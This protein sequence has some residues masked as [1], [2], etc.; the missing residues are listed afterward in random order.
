MA[1]YFQILFWLFI[2]TKIVYVL[3]FSGAALMKMVEVYKEIQS[4]QM[5]IV[6]TVIDI[7]KCII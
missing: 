2:T 6:S 3:L 1:R 7:I 5:I 4:Q